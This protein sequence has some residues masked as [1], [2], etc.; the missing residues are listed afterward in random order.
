MVDVLSTRLGELQV[1][2]PELREEYQPE[3]AYE[4]VP[5]LRVQPR[6]AKP[7]SATTSPTILRLP[8]TRPLILLNP[9]QPL[10]EV[11]LNSQGL[12]Q[13]FIYEQRRQRVTCCSASET[14]E[15][16]WWLGPTVRRDYHR[17]QTSGGSQY[18]VYR[19]LDDDRWFLHGEF[20]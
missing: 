16:G 5:A 20:L 12:P 9:P 10:H 8:S 6:A 19:Q 17:V 7:A 11:M 1:V 13:E 4:A 18:W 2:R 15:T 3:G 14:I